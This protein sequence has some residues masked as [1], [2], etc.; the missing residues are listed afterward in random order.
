MEGGGVFPS[1]I[2]VMPE[3]LPQGPFPLVFKV[4]KEKVGARLPDPMFEK[5]KVL[6]SDRWVPWVD[7]ESVGWAT[8]ETP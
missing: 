8:L 3:E 5:L 2:V 6:V 7:P 1:V 4:S